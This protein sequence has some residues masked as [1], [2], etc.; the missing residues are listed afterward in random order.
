M[1]DGQALYDSTTTWNNQAWDVDDVSE[2]LL[3]EGKIKDY[4]VVGIW[5]SG[6]SAYSGDIVP[7]IPVI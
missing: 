2:L 5:N 3:E 7:V 1:H 4:V 6:Q